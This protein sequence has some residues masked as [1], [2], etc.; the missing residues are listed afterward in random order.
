MWVS[1]GRSALCAS[2]NEEFGTLADNNPLTPFVIFRDDLLDPNRLEITCTSQV[3][4]E[5][6]REQARLH[7]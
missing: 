4:E 7:D 5:S 1:S 6:G 3:Y 2:A